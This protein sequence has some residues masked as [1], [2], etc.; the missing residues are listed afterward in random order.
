MQASAKLAWLREHR[1]ALAGRARFAMPLPDWLASVLTGN[2]VASRTLLIENGMLEVCPSAAPVLD[3]VREF[4]PPGVDNGACCGEVPG[5]AMRGTSVVLSGGDTQCALVGMGAMVIGTAGVSAGWSAPVQVV[6]ERPIHDA[7]M[8][9]WVGAHAVHG[10]WVVESNAGETGR[11][12]AWLLE[13]LGV[14]AV[15]AD[16]LAGSSALGARDVMTVL[17]PATMNAAAMNA[18]IGGITLPLPI[19]MSSP[20]RS[21]LLRSVLE[22]VAF[23]V[24]ANLEQAEGVAGT[25]ADELRF[26]GG[27][28][29]SG[30]FTQIVADVVDRRVLVATTPETTALGAAVVAAPALAIHDSLAKAAETMVGSMR[31][32]EPS[33]KNSAAYEDL[34]Q[35]WLAMCETFESLA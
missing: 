19:V 8:R 25:R 23:A 7:A 28:S 30:V 21:D 20:E 10:R 29:R 14:G 3:P 1:P 34:Y 26:G 2:P 27:M 16:A 15:E 4:V 6:T 32:V 17:G 33:A 13:L 5:G 12:W 22:S 35:R 24:R 18:S 9:T 11:V 31:S